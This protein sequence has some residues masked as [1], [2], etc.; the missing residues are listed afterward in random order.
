MHTHNIYEHVPLLRRR[1]I[2]EPGRI[3]AVGSVAAVRR[4]AHKYPFARCRQYGTVR[5]A[6]NC[7]SISG[8]GESQ[9]VIIYTHKQRIY[10]WLVLPWSW[11]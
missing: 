5:T 8:E 1:S 11:R 9:K 10:V 2:T 7:V 4:V 3:S 6:A